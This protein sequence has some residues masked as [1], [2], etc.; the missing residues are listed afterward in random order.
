[1]TFLSPSILWL[2]G[3]IGIPIAIHILSLM[4]VNKVE[5]SSI[6]FIKELKTSSI[7]KIRNQKLLL[8]LLRILIIVCLVMMM[9]QPV[10]K[11]FM[12]GWISAEQD[13]RL[14]FV[15]DNSASMSVKNG[16]KSLLDQSKSIVMTLIPQFNPETN[17]N[18]F[19]TCPPKLIYSGLQ[20]SSGLRNA[21]KSI[22]PTA[23]YDNL[24]NSI[25][26]GLADGTMA[27]PIKECVVLSDM[28]HAPDSLF[29]N[30]IDKLKEWKFYFI[31]PNPVKSNVGVLDASLA[32]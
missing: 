17:I 1:M 31:E 19:Q 6:R 9:A 7:R 27:E 23:S 25:L 22:R 20:N 30:A 24:W 13:A 18:I 16:E 15:I 14:V 2:I 5:F 28:M 10:T 12:P 21:L 11:G 26:K 3:A 29:H 4:R 32:A 8:L